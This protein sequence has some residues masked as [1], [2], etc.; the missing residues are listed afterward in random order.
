MYEWKEPPERLQAA[1]IIGMPLQPNG[2]MCADFFGTS[3]REQLKDKIGQ[4]RRDMMHMQRALTVIESKI[5]A[6]TSAADMKS[7]FTLLYFWFL[8]A[9]ESLF[10]MTWAAYDGGKVKAVIQDFQNKFSTFTTSRTVF[11]SGRPK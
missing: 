7:D 8:S 9:A 1:D 3:A 5:R 4:M 10:A 6:N 11:L 2:Q